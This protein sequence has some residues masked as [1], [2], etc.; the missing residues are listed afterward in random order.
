MGFPSRASGKEPT[1][2]CRRHKRHGFD[3]ESGRSPGRGHA[4]PLQYSCLENPMDREALQATVHSVTKWTR[5]KQLSTHAESEI[6]FRC[7]T[8][9]SYVTL[10]RYLVEIWMLNVFLVRCQKETLLGTGGKITFVVQSLSHVWLFVISWTA[11]CQASL[12]F[13]ICSNSCPSIPWWLRW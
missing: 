13:T 11:A 8:G 4:N 6:I 9:K 3:P 7:L 10:W 1:C 5:L 2:R 12:S